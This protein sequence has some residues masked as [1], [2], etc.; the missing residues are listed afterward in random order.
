MR[1]SAVI[2]LA[3]AACNSSSS[4]EPQKKTEEPRKLAG[5]Y[6]ENFRCDSIA[7]EEALSAVFAAPVRTLDSPSSIPRGVPH[8]CTYEVQRQPQ[9]EYWTFDFDCRDGYKRTADALFEQ[10]T[11]TSSE[12]V[13]QFNTASDAAPIPDP[14]PKKKEPKKDMDAGID[15]PQ[16]PPEEASAVQVGAKGLDHHGQ[17]LLFIDD[18]APCYVRIVGP[19]K[20]RRL[21]LAQ[22]IAKNLTFANA[23]MTPRPFK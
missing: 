6:P 4:G 15:A 17:G 23:P 8:P 16:R 1:C 20:E 7:T 10:Y 2:L 3:C 5:I 9:P 18:D 22:L 13:E 21:A 14:T 12:L 11:R 19:D